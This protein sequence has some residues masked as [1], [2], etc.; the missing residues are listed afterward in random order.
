MEK[1]C[2]GQ[3]AECFRVL[4]ITRKKLNFLFFVS[5]FIYYETDRDSVSRRGAEREGE[6]ENPSASSEPDAGLELM[7]P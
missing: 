7:R 2:L 1:I 5:S 3:D 4:Y 6:R